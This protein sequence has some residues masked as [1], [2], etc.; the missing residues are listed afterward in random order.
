MTAAEVR[1]AFLD[2]FAEHGHTVVPS[3]SLVPGGDATLLFTNAGMVQF[4][5]VFLG[6][7]R[8]PYTRAV[9]A[10]RCMR[11][12][13]KHN[14]LENV[15][16]SP[17][18]HT[19]FEM[20]GNFS[21]GDYFKR[22]AIRYAY[23]CVTQVY[24]LDPARLYFTVHKDDDEAY[25]IW[26]DD[27]KVDPA[28]VARLGDKS[29][30]WQ[31]ADTGPCGPTSELHYDFNP[32]AAALTG[33]ELA[34]HLDDNPDGRFLEIWNLVFM[35]Y[36]Q[37]PDGARTPLPSPGVDTGLGLERIVAIIQGVD[38]SYD[39]DLFTPILA[40]IQQLTG[41]GDDWRQQPERRVA[42]RVIADHARAAVNLI[43]DG[44]VP[45]NEGRH[46]VT[47]MVIRRAARYGRKL[48]FGEP[49]LARVAE[50]VIAELSGVYPELNRNREAI[51]QTLTLEER[52]FMRT[53]DMG[54]ENLEAI[55]GDLSRRGQRQ[56]PGD[57]AFN[58]HST[59]GLP[60]EITRDVAQER[61]L[62]VD[63]A[64]FHAAM[65]AHK[66]V[67]GAGQDMGE[68]GGEDVEVYRTLFEELKREGRLDTDGVEYDPYSQLE[69]EGPVLALLAEGGRRVKQARP[70]ER[71][72]AVLPH[73]P[74]YIEAGGQVADTGMIARYQEG[75][76]DPLWEIRVDTVR[77][78]AAGIIVHGGIV[79]SGTPAEGDVAWAIV[80]DERRW[81][82]MRNH[83][84][85]HLLHAE[86]RYV[87][88]EHVRQA[89]SLVAPG[90]LRFDFTHHAMVTQDELAA[91]SRNVNDAALANYPVQVVYQAR[92]EA[93][94]AGAMAL[95]GEKYGEVVRT[96]QIGEPSPFSYELCGGTHVPETA[97]IGP[98]LVL[99]ESSVGSGVRRIEAV[100]GRV[101][102]EMIH[103]RLSALDNA[104]AYLGVPPDEVDRKVLGLLDE[105]QAAQKEVRRLQRQLKLRDFENQL[106]NVQS[107]AGVPVLAVNVGQAAPDQLREMTDWFRQKMGSGVVVLGGMVEGKPSLVASVTDDLVPRGL[108][109]VQIVR[110]IAK[111]V[112]G[113]G[114]GKPTLAQAGGKDASKLNDALAQV[115]GLVER[116]LEAR[117]GK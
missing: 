43:S 115:P 1:Q 90:R 113:G 54:L 7:D 70:G 79:A 105:A 61:G 39:T 93:I 75:V 20:L 88:G 50:T 30:F 13:G 62:T 104:S 91:I 8:R 31:M 38:N 94:A 55:L 36:N 89:G 84:A 107:V 26:V 9:T 103:R 2:F 65:Q 67:S 33:E 100:T 15:G 59:Y 111:V 95:F 57:V 17:R 114:G 12:S 77:R 99:S 48:G 16:P 83:T 5:D 34:Y 22:E 21:F 6:T 97:D 106:A 85:T 112:G 29:N 73:T 64:A 46:Y 78:P 44:V 18:H 27:M 63:E 53:M 49:F 108:D 10:Q 74:F 101:A 110:G 42:Y 4:K 40:R 86:L 80:D 56:L 87:L 32:G 82:I 11:V 68:L 52:R 19:F 35:Q 23:D 58:L 41:D 60:L 92:E 37:A 25:R 98:F 116:A 51:F 14:D 96:V 117:N 3:S 76:D 72:E 45:G 66:L 102:L 69:T 28:R 24:G 47:R 71:V 109:A 81:D